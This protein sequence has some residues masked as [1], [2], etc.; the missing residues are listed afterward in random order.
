LGQKL[1]QHF[2]ANPG[3]LDRIA[4]AVSPEGED[5]VIE[6]GPGKGALTERLL[7]RAAR[8]IAIEVDRDMV[9]HLQEKFAGETRLEIVHADVLAADLAQWGRVP[10]VGNLPY[11][12]T[13]PILERTVGLDV[14][15]LVFL[16][17]KEVAERLV[18]QPSSRDYG[19][20]T[21]ATR[22]YA[23]ARIL[24]NVKPGA[25][26][27]PPRVDSSVVLLTPVRRDFGVEPRSR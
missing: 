2:L 1:G 16:M 22:L 23:D 3:I 19:Y 15:R 13:S 8:V 12:I 4:L 6:I 7:Q 26:R 27:P 20:L 24:F 9:A 21:L 18:A 5:L 14:P 11:Y 10:I 25:F 17:Q